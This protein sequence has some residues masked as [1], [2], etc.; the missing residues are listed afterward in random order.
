M[1]YTI[2]NNDDN[3]LYSELLSHY[4][5]TNGTFYTGLQK[6]RLAEYAMMTKGTY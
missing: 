5:D 2:K 3:L 1:L 4:S 6:R